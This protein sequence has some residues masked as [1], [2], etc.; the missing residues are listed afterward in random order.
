MTTLEYKYAIFY[1]YENKYK[2]MSNDHMIINKQTKINGNEDI[3]KIEDYIKDELIKEGK[4][5]KRLV[6]TDFNELEDK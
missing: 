3:K 4:S 1:S 2:G 6:I 5:I